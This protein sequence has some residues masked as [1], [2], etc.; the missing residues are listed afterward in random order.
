VDV[1]N[2]HSRC[3]ESENET[4]V[5]FIHYERSTN[6]LSNWPFEDYYGLALSEVPGTINFVSVFFLTSN[7]FRSQKNASDLKILST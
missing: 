2:R 1:R 6:K 4:P 3:C 5:A 7:M